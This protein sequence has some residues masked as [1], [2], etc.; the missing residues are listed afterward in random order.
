MSEEDKTEDAGSNEVAAFDWTPHVDAGVD[1]SNFPKTPDALAKEFVGLR[2]VNGKHASKLESA[3]F[4]PGEDATPEDRDAFYGK[5]GRPDKPE[6]YG[7]EAPEAGGEFGKAAYTA[8]QAAGH[9]AGLSKAQMKTFHDEYLSGIKET[10]GDLEAAQ[11]RLGDELKTLWGDDYS[12]K[13]EDFNRSMNDIL[14]A[15]GAAEFSDLLMQSGLLQANPAGAA[16]FMDMASQIIAARKEGD[17]PPMGAGSGGAS[18]G[19][20]RERL[21]NFRSQ[22]TQKLRDKDPVAIA[23]WRKLTAEVANEERK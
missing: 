6:E 18:G 19:T 20:A 13:T 5:L 2:T 15:D 4:I 9:K 12:A 10:G 1:T 16:K 7:L 17:P 8:M 22:N 3:L 14:G 11:G 21:D 23:Q